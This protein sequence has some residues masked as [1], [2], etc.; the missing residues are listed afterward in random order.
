[1]SSRRI[2]AYMAKSFSVFSTEDRA[3]PAAPRIFGKFDVE[4]LASGLQK[5][6]EGALPFIGTI[7]RPHRGCGLLAGEGEIEAQHGGDP[8]VHCVVT[9]IAFSAL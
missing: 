7:G 6:N 2:E 5:T 4:R 1:M 3:H 8:V 9:R